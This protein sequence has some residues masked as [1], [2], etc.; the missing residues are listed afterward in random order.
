M[1][2]IAVLAILLVVTSACSRT[3][4]AYRKAD[5]L[6][7]YYAW[8]TLDASDSQ[9]DDWQPVLQTTLQRH[10]QQELPLVIAYLDQVER[11]IRE[12]ETPPGAPCL[13]DGALWLYQ[14]HAHL[15][16][17]LAVPLL[18][19]LEAGQI[20]QLA[21]YTKQRQ[22][23]A[24]GEYLNPDPQRREE[25]RRERITGRIEKWTGALD[26]GQ[27]QLVSDTLARIPDMSASWLEYRAQ[28]TS[29]LIDMLA[30]GAGTVS[31]R[32]YL[33]GWW[34]YRD[35]T[36]AETREYWQVARRETVQLIRKLIENLTSTQR[37][38]LE[39][40][41]AEVRQDLAVFVTPAAEPANLLPVTA[42]AV[43][44]N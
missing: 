22:E 41:L 39:N 20:R 42:C 37:A 34:V 31:L 15:A 25:A 16:V 9:L 28:R 24:I 17:D 14:R 44:T 23:D 8:K 10:R 18:A 33:E 2:R 26:Q 32:A 3:E 35:G 4:F 12:P 13:V 43:I 7:E 11:F 40:R 21:D 19:G 29:E 27:R 38:T 5:W 1:L 30:A 6:L 36:S